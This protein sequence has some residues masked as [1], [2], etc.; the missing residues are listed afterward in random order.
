[1]TEPFISYTRNGKEIVVWRALGHVEH[2]RFVD[3]GAA[4][5]IGHSATHARYPRDGAGFGLPAL[6]LLHTGSP[7]IVD[8]ALPALRYMSEAGR[9]RWSDV[10]VDSVSNAMLQV[11]T[12]I[13]RPSCAGM[14]IK[15]HCPAGPI[16]PRPSPRS[17]DLPGHAERMRSRKPMR[18]AIARGSC[19][20]RCPAPASSDNSA[21]PCAWAS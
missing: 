14:P 1:M 16:S 20:R 17:S 4:D 15:S 8:M 5:P 2:G 10:T 3:V 6:E 12:P 7:L 11:A 18:M 13:A 9:I 19:R 21:A